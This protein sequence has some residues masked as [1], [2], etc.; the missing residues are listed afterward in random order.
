MNALYFWIMSEVFSISKSTLPDNLSNIFNKNLYSI[1]YLS[2]S[3]SG[4]AMFTEEER[5]TSLI[6]MKKEEEAEKKRV[7]KKLGLLMI[8]L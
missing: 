2:W 4:N 5:K 6:K 1:K 3:A 8:H 7:T